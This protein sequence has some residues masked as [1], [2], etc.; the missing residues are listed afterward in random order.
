MSGCHSPSSAASRICDNP[1][2]R[3]RLG[4]IVGGT[5]GYVLGARAG[6]ERYEQLARSAASFRNHPA[7]L[8]LKS[9]ATGVTDLARTGAAEGLRAGSRQMRAA[10]D[11]ALV[12]SVEQSSGS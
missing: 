3:F 9:Q 2:M 4:M 11:D 5:I 6:R 1:G 7:Y 8:Q 12:V 10:A